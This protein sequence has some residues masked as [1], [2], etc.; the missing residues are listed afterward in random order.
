MAH[1][2]DIQHGGDYY[3][4]GITFQH[5]DLCATFNVG[6]LEGNATKYLI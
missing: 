6:Y 5:W 2:N 4:R 1:P 3:K